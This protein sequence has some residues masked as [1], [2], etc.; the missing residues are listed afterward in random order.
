MVIVGVDPSFT[1]TGVVVLDLDSKTFTLSEIKGS[2]GRSFQ[3]TYFQS[4][5]RSNRLF[6]YLRDTLKLTSDTIIHTEIPFPNREASCGLYQLDSLLLESFQKIT[7]DIYM[8]NPMHLAHIHGKRKYSKSDSVAL[9]HSLL[10][11]FLNNG[12]SVSK[13]RY[14]HNISEAMLYVFR[15]YVREFNDELSNQLVKIAPNLKSFKEEKLIIL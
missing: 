15:S 14:S 8:S 7:T 9:S 13:K 12:Y 6:L 5:D 2:M 4:R 3:E 1:G 11:V 10:E